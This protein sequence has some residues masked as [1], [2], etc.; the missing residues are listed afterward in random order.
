MSK[1]T[2]EKT[3]RPNADWIAIERDYR[4]GQFSN[5]EL[6]RIHGVSDVA[7]L[8]RARKYEW[9]KD[10]APAVAQE[11]SARLATDAVSGTVS[12][13]NTK[14]IIDAA[15]ARGV[16]I[17]RGHRVTIQRGQALVNLLF[18]QLEEAATMRADIEE[19][20]ENETAGD[21]DTKRRNMMLK[22]VSL[23]AHA[24]VIKDLGN[25]LGKLVFLERQ[26]FNID[27]RGAGDQ[28]ANGVLRMPAAQT[29]EE[30]LSP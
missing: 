30:W 16:E 9:K 6:G 23:P 18:G 14:E 1:A 11:I 22:A 7:V 4:T 21:E 27:G 29:E 10:V 17:V 5:R 20:I 24:G 26:A 25:A 8:K 12:A 28:G 19:M 2:S 3:R 13:A 15:A